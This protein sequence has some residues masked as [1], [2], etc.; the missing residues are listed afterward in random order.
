MCLLSE[1]DD[2]SRATQKLSS[3]VFKLP[4]FN[5]PEFMAFVDEMKI[6]LNNHVIGSTNDPNYRA[7]DR[8]LP[9]INQRFTEL[10]L[11][12]AT[13]NHGI[14]TLHSAQADYLHG[15]F[16][17]IKNDVKSHV[18][19]RQRQLVVAMT[20]F[21]KEGVNKMSDVVVANLRVDSIEEPLQNIDDESSINKSNA[22]Q[23]F[24]A[25]H[26]E[27]DNLTA[28]CDSNGE[29]EPSQI[30][31]P[32]MESTTISD[33]MEFQ[34]VHGAYMKIFRL[35]HQKNFSLRSL[36]EEYFGL[37]EFAGIPVDGG[38]WGLEKKFKNRWRKNK[39]TQKEDLLFSRV[40]KLCRGVSSMAKVS[41]GVWSKDVSLV[42]ERWQPLMSHGIGGALS[43]LQSLSEIEK[44]ETRNRTNLSLTIQ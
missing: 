2:D 20:S 19:N 10:S 37:N 31:V 23:T 36:Y 24:P 17:D 9:G 5:T 1:N 4:V 29:D 26:R 34:R 30:A 35:G 43:R 38:F 3:S 21:F 42:I 18:D 15:E 8:C 27:S 14:D 16:L 22:S 12:L 40:S 13:M 7:V 6:V 33:D 28:L 44:R 11:Q 32:A 41:M 25:N 39:Y